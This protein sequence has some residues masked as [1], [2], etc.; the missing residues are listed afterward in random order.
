LYKHSLQQLRSF[1]AL[2]KNW[3]NDNIETDRH[4]VET[5]FVKARVDGNRSD[6]NR[7]R[8]ALLCS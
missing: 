4:E 2:E 1:F 3:E 6:L 5:F 7:C 8:V